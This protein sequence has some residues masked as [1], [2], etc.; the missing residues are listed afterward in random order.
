MQVA[1][2][3]VISSQQRHLTEAG[4]VLYSFAH[5]TLKSSSLDMGWSMSCFQQDEQ[6]QKKEFQ[7][8]TSGRARAGA[9]DASL[10]T[11]L[12]LCVRA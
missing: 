12:S 8:A 5:A 7:D 2:I 10:A 11:I 1:I 6:G 3:E 9:V 4:K